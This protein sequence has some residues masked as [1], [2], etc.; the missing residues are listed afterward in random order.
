MDDQSFRK[1]AISARIKPRSAIYYASRMVL[2][3]GAT[4]EVAA[5]LCQIKQPTVSIAVKRIKQTIAQ[6]QELAASINQQ[7]EP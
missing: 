6:A 7:E 4:Q 5:R 2:V 3:G 1:A